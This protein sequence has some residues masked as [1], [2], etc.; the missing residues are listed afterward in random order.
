MGAGCDHFLPHQLGLAGGKA[1]PGASGAIAGFLS[2]AFSG[3]FSGAFSGVPR[4]RRQVVSILPTA[5][6]PVLPGE[7]VRAGPGFRATGGLRPV[8]LAAQHP[9][10]PPVRGHHR[11]SLRQGLERRF[12]SDRYQGRDGA[13]SCRLCH[14]ATGLE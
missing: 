9:H 12:R 11:M 3:T 10:Q 1:P 5:A 2:G 7:N 6:A 14:E 4:Q 8:V 13:L